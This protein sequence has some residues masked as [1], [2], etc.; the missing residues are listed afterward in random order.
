MAHVGGAVESEGKR[1]KKARRGASSPRVRGRGRRRR[2][3]SGG[4]A[5]AFDAAAGGGEKRD[6]YGDCGVP[7]AIPCTGR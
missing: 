2:G 1:E 5:V 4:D 6:G 7:A 3:R